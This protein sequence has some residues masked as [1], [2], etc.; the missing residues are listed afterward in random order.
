MKSFPYEDLVIFEIGAGNGTLAKDILD[1]IKREHPEVYERTRY[2][3][4][5]ISGR[6]AECQREKLSPHKAVVSVTHKSIF[7]WDQTVSSPC[8]FLS[9]E[10]IVSS[11][12]LLFMNLS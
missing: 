5:E 11:L 10:V 1:H 8:F 3:I 6:L 7:H 4:V 9:M 2:H 12:F